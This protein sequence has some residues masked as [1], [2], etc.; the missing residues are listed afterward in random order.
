MSQRG[1]RES[2]ACVAS[3]VLTFSDRMTNAHSANGNHHSMVEL[4]LSFMQPAFLTPSIPCDGK[5]KI[6]A[7]AIIG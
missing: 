1:R 3:E 6:I 5:E 7:N 2:L 4:F